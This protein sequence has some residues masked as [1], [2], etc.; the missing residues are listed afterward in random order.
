MDVPTPRLPPT[1]RFAAAGVWAAFPEKGASTLLP[2]KWSQGIPPGCAEMKSPVSVLIPT[3]N[4]QAN[5]AACISTL[6]WAAEVLIVD[7]NSSDAT[8]EEARREGAKVFVHE[9]EG[10]A[11]QR[12]WALDHL[13]FAHEWILVLDADE[14][15]PDA[16]ADEIVRVTKDAS[17]PHNGFYLDRRFFFM[18]RWLKHGGLSP[19]W[20]LRLF[21]RHTGRF[22]DRPFNEHL[23][24][25]G[26]AGYLKPAFDHIDLRPLSTWI[27]KHN[28]YADLQVEDELGDRAGVFVHTLEPSLGA[29]SIRRK[30]WIRRHVWNRIPLLLR[31]FL[32]FLHNYALKG[33]FLDGNPGFIY[34]VLWSFWFPFL[35]DVKILERRMAEAKGVAP[36]I[37][38]RDSVTNRQGNVCGSTETRHSR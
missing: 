10:Y 12:N 28:R 11:K 6:K 36:S 9:F 23:L 3:C 17:H 29:N 37:N 25:E 8:V 15:I 31:P 27:N 24:L 21:K 1:H 22:E 2:T 19:N 16:L 32:L 26:E 30:R 38:P 5:I 4:E 13:P 20:I 7:A 33:G 18:G 14:R 35:V 34:H